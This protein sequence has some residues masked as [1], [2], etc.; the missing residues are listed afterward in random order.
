MAARRCLF[1]LKAYEADT[2]KQA[3]DQLRRIASKMGLEPS[4]Q[5]PL[6][7]TIRKWTVLRSPHVHKKSRETFEM[8]THKRLVEIIVPAEK[9][10]T[11]LHL[12]QHYRENLPGVVGL[13]IRT[14]EISPKKGVVLAAT[15]QTDS[16]ASAAAAAPTS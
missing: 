5:I 15:P 10:N 1:Q 3:A 4:G 7:T 13:R 9:Q 14:E 16:S 12:I 6:P 11:A 8:R 2:V